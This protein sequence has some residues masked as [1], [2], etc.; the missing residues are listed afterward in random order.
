MGTF[1]KAIVVVCIVGIV[2]ILI[3]VMM[4]DS[5]VQSAPAAAD[6]PTGTSFPDSG[7]NT[8]ADYSSRP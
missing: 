6:T 7:D 8:G 3:V 2:G 4:P 1:L 5:P